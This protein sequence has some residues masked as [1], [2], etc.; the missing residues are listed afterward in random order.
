VQ[1]RRHAGVVAQHADGALAVVA[2]AADGCAH[3]VG[4]E[5]RQL[6]DVLLDQV[7]ELQQHGLPLGRLPLAPWAGECLA[8][9]GDGAVDVLAVT[10]GDV[11][12]KLAGRGIAAFEGL[13]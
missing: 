13:A 6:L 8:R 4:V 3:V 7:G 9:R 2:R 11:R 1:R 12:Q 5:R 10:L